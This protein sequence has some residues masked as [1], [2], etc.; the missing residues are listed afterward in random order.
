LKGVSSVLGAVILAAIIFTVL[1]PLLIFLQNTTT[2]YHLQVLE[3]NRFEIERFQ[4]NLEIHA[5]VSPENNNLYLL[6][7]NKG[8]LAVNL[9]SVYI[10]DSGGGLTI[11][12]STGNSVVSPL[13]HILPI[14]LTVKAEEGKAYTI[15][16][17]TERGRSYAAAEKPLNITDPPYILQVSVINMMFDRKYKIKVTVVEMKTT[18]GKFKVGCVSAENPCSSEALY[19]YYSSRWNDNQT[20][21]FRVMPGNYSIQLTEY[22]FD[23]GSGS[24]ISTYRGYQQTLMVLKSSV[25]VFA[26]EH[27]P[28]TPIDLNSQ[29]NMTLAVPAVLM[30][31]DEATFDAYIVVRL[32]DIVKESMRDATVSL[33][34]DQT[35]HC[36]A[37]IEGRDSY[38]LEIIKPGQTISL[39][40]RIRVSDVDPLLGGVVYIKGSLTSAVGD[41]TGTLY[42]Y[43]TSITPVSIC[44]LSELQMIKRLAVT[45]NCN[46]CADKCDP[47]SVIDCIKLGFIYLCVC[48]DSV[49]MVPR[50]GQP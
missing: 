33:I 18:N 41:R 22:K 9:T 34:I 4:E 37:T 10:A 20:F 5:T 24:W 11:W 31:T 6:V 50:C 27:V 13:S 43:E 44:K 49:G 19:E 12:N 1:I 35:K 47:Y 29:F 48:G 45:D 42:N 7:K 30:V 3:R 46:K 38:N 25:V 16:V 23:E 17:A 2:L 28:A 39:D 40:F 21:T 36:T 26:Y 14:N 32:D 15:H 8:S